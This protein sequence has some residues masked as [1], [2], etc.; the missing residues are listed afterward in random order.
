[1]NSTNLGSRTIVIIAVV[2]VLLIAGGFIF[3][4]AL[5]LIFP[6]EAS[7][8]ARQVD[9]LFRILLI[10]GGAIFLLVQGMLAFSVWRFRAKPGETGDGI[11]LHGNTTLEIV[12]TAIPAVIVFVLS[13]LSYQVF[14]SEQ[15][16]KDNE[17]IVHVDGRRFSWAFSYDTTV[18]DPQNEG[19]T[20]VVQAIDLHTY[21]GQP[22]L[23]QMES[24]DVIHALWIPAF[25]IKQDLI[26]GRVTSQRFT[27]VEVD[28]TT[29]PTEYPIRCAELCGANHGIMTSKV[30][31]YKSQAEYQAWLDA[32]IDKVLHPPADPVIRG[33]QILASNIYPCYTCH[34]LNIPDAAAP[35]TGA[36]GPSLNGIGDRA[37]G[38]RAQSTGLTGEAYLHQS[39]QDPHA[40]LVPGYGPLMP[41]LG[42]D[43]CTIQAIVAY[44]GTQT[45]SGTPAF[46]IDQDAF[47][48]QCGGAAA[49]E[50]T[51]EATVGAEATVSA[52]N[53]AEATIPPA[54]EEPIEATAAPTTAPTTVPT[55]EATSE[56]TAGT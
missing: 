51:A 4:Q 42:L 35:W 17:A 46:T 33:H 32:E 5:P 26:P 39:L 36:V 52:E 12:W 14:V 20:V 15:T 45:E 55:S 18:P 37:V 13:I 6:P 29:Y 41:D 8:E 43:E 22:V 47:A 54:G 27:P 2:G 11:V 19:K 24:Q 44:L 1:M 49:A 7:A 16:P 53:T 21:I 10:I 28:G 38:V 25:R 30:I 48:A 56:A 40:Y 3:A 34:T 9:E 23:L 31:V 50:A